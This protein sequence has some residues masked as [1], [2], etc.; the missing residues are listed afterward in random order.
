[1]G[2]IMEDN[3][4]YVDQ[5]ITSSNWDIMLYLLYNNMTS[6]GN[7]MIYIYIYIYIYTYIYTYIQQDIMEVL[8]G[9]NPI[10]LI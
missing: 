1:M 5:W 2:Y 4:I 8:M 10:P 3:G 6:N 7:T 9:Y